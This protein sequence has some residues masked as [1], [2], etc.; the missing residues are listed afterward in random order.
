MIISK[1]SHLN[2]L[3]KEKPLLPLIEEIC[4]V[5]Q[6]LL[7]RKLEENMKWEKPP[8]DLLHWIRVLNL[9]DDIFEKQIAHY[10]LALPHPKLAE[11]APDDA[12]LLVACLRFSAMLLDHCTNR[13]IYASADR[14]FHL[15]NAYTIDVKLAALEV[16]YFLGERYFQLSRAKRFA[17][18][19][20]VRTRLVEFATCFPPP[21]PASFIQKR[22]ASQAITASA[23]GT[24]PPS[25][26]ASLLSSN[27]APAPTSNNDHYSLVDTLD[28]KKKYPSKWKSLNF[29][30][31]SAD[32]DKKKN[33]KPTEGVATF[34]LSDEQVRKMSLEQMYDKACES[35]PKE[36]WSAFSLAAL[37]AKAFNTKL[38][39]SMKLRSK[40]LRLKCVAVSCVVFNC[41]SDFTSFNL[42]EVEPYTFGALVA[43]ISPEH[44]PLI[45][46]DIF[47]WALKTLEC[48]SIK[49]AWGSELVRHLGGNVSHGLLYQLLRY[50]NKKI[51]NEDDDCF[52]KG[53]LVFFTMLGNLVDSKSLSP[54][55]AS[56]GLLTDL[57]QF[58]NVRTKFRWTCS[59][60][61]NN[62]AIFL[63]A[64]P[65][66]ITEF[67]ND[68]GFALLVD[69]INYE[70]GF[71]LE[72]PEFGGGTPKDNNTYYSITLRQVN[73]IRNLLKLV[74]HLIQSDAGDRLRNLF[75]SSILISFNKIISNPTV[76]GPFVVAATL[77]AV[78]HII[79]NEPTAYSILKE[80][81]VIDT[82]V[83]NYKSLFLPS[84]ELIL[85][86]LEILGAI[87]LNKDGL[88]TVSRAFCLDIF[89]NSF[90]N[91]SI[92]KE[93]LRTEMNTSIGCS[94]DE[95]ARHYPSLRPYII[96][97]VCRL[98]EGFADFVEPKLEPIRFYTSE[99]YGSFYNSPTDEVISQEVG[100]SEIES[101]E[102]SEGS[103]L[104]D[105]FEG[106]FCGLL[107]DSGQWGKDI[108][109]K[110]PSFGLQRL[111]VMLNTPSDYTDS[112]T[113][114]NICA[115]LK[116]VTDEDHSSGLSCLI[117]DIRKYLKEPRIQ[118]FIK[119]TG[120]ESYFYG[121]SENPQEATEVLK[122]LNRLSTCLY[123]LTET[124]LNPNQMVN[125]VFD[126]F[127]VQFGVS[128]SL[129][130]DLLKLMQRSIIEELTFRT[131]LPPAVMDQTSPV[132]ESGVAALPLQI[133]AKQ[134]SKEAAHESHTS[135]KYKNTLQMRFLA[136]RF[137]HHVALIFSCI[138][139]SC[140]HR[141]QDYFTESWREWAVQLTE[142]M[143][144]S[145]YEL[146]ASRTMF[147]SNL[148]PGYELVALNIILSILLS[149]DR[150]KDVISTSLLL[151]FY[152]T[153]E[154][155]ADVVNATID[156]FNDI[157][158]LPEEVLADVTK[159]KFIE[160]SSA[161]IK[162]NFLTRALLLLSQVV[163]PAYVVRLP[164]SSLFYN[165]EYCPS[166]SAVTDGILSQGSL[167]CVRLIDSLVG[168][169]SK[170][171]LSDDFSAFANLPAETVDLIFIIVR[172]VWSLEPTNDYYPLDAT[173][174]TPARGEAD[175][176]QKHLKIDVYAADNILRI[177]KSI[178]HIPTVQGEYT[179]T[180]QGDVND[181]DWTRYK[182]ILEKTDYG[183]RFNYDC[184]KTEAGTEVDRMRRVIGDTLFT[185]T[186]FKIAAFTTKPID[187]LIFLSKFD[188]EKF[189]NSLLHRIVDLSREKSKAN[190]FQLSNLVHLFY[191]FVCREPFLVR[192]KLHEVRKAAFDQFLEFFLSEME[193]YPELGDSEYFHAGLLCIEPVFSQTPPTMLSDVDPYLPDM[194]GIISFKGRCSKAVLAL[195]PKDNMEAAIELCRFAYLLAKE[196]EFKQDVIQSTLLHSIINKMGTYVS[197]D[198]RDQLKGLQDSLILLVRTCFENK[199]FLQTI[200]SSEITRLYEKQQS[201]RRDLRRL[202]DE[203]RFLVARDA[204][205]YIETA[206]KLL[207]LENFDGK[208]QSGD[209]VFLLKNE[210]HSN[211]EDTNNEDTQMDVDGN[212]ELKSTG[213]VHLL[214]SQMM[215][216]SKQ[217][218]TSSPVSPEEEQKSDD[219]MSKKKLTFEI[220]MQN[221]NFGYLCFL[222]QTLTEL[223]GS[224]KNAKLEFIT[225]SKKGVYDAKHKPRSTS[226]NFFIH[227]LLLNHLLASLSGP[228]HQ[229]REAVSSLAKVSLLALVSTT[230]LENDAESQ[231][232]ME[233]PDMA[234][235][236]KFTV[237]V[238]SKTLKDV[239]PGSL[240][241]SETYSKIYEVFDLCACLLSSK[242]RELCYPLLNKNATKADQ[243]YI[244]A[245][246]LDSQLPNQI[247]SVIA[248]L[249]LNFPNITKVTKVG[250]KPLSSLA[251]I[252]QSHA[253][254]FESN[255]QGEKDEEDIEDIEDKD[256]TPDL[257]RNSTLGMY[258]VDRESEEDSFDDEGEPLDAIMSGSDVSGDETEDSND[259][260]SES[261]DD[262]MMEEDLEGALEEGLVEGRYEGYDSQDSENDIEIIDELEIHS[263]SG[264]DDE[265]T[266][267]DGFYG[268]SDHYD[269]GGEADED[270]EE[271][272][273][274]LD[275]D[276]DE[277]DEED[278]EDIDDV[279]VLDDW[280]MAFG[281]EAATPSFREH[282]STLRPDYEWPSEE[283]I[284]GATE[285]ESNFESE[286]DEED[287]E[288][289]TS[290]RTREFVTSFVDALRP[291]GQQNFSSFFNGLIHR[292]SQPDRGL[293]RGSI[294]IGDPRPY[295]DFFSHNGT[296][297]EIIVDD[298]RNN[299]LKKSLDYM[300]IRS[301]TERWREA[302]A[303]HFRLFEARL[304]ECARSSIVENIKEASYEIFKKKEE[305]KE[306]LRKQKEEK[307]AK[308]KE[309]QRKKRE[310]E[311]RQREAEEAGQP[312]TDREPVLLWIGDREVDISG[313][314]IDPGFFEALP[315]DMREEVFTQHVRERRA[316]ASNTAG[317]V[318]EIDPDFLSALPEQIRDDILQQESLARRYS[319]DGFRYF[320]DNEEGED[321]L[322]DESE[323]DDGNDLHATSSQGEQNEARERKPT[324][325]KKRTYL[326]TP[327]LDRS[328][329]AS[330]V[331]L[332]FVPRPINQRENIYL[333]LLHICDNKHTRVDV[334]G[335]LIAILF[336]G[337]VSQKALERSFGLISAK[338]HSVKVGQTDFSKSFPLGATPV[339]IGYQMIEAV[340]YLVEKNPALRLFLLTEH[341]NP[342]LSTRQ[343]KNRLKDPATCEE[344]YPI[345][346]LLKLL[347]NP[348]LTEEHFFTELLASVLHFGTRPL[349]LLRE[350]KSSV[351]L[352]FSTSFIPDRNLRLIIR[353]LAS[354]ECT[355]STFRRALSAMQHLSLLKNAQS[356][357]SDELSGKSKL[358]GTHI[359]R[360][361]K[362]LTA[363]IVDDPQTDIH[364][365]KYVS[366]FTAPSS[367]QSKLLRVL[368]ALDYMYETN[369][370]QKTEN[371]ESGNEKS[372]IDQLTVLYNHLQLGLLWDALSDCL[373]VLEESSTLSTI[374]TALLPLIEALMV[375]CKHSKVKEIQ[376]KDVM[377][378]EAKKIDFTKEP[379]ESLFFSF[380][381]EHKKI[382]NQMVRSNPN[383]M[384]GPF[385]MLVRNPRVLEFDNKK[386]YFD[387][388][389]HEDPENSHK[390]AVSIRRD[391]VFL[392][393]YRAL[394]FKSLEEF[395]KARLEIAFKGEAGIDAGGVT[396]EWYQVL[397]RQMFNPDYALF[398]AVASDETTFHPNRTSYINP[399]HLSFFK[400]I[401]RVIGKAIYDGSFLDCHFSR[402][403]YKAILNR[404]VSL[405]DMENLDLE[406]FK[407]LMWMLEND[408]TDIITEDFSVETDD[409]GEHKVIDLVENGRNIPVTEENKQEYVRLVV[410]YRLQTSVKE[411]MS[412]F[413]TGF[414]EII[415]QD[416][417]AIFDEQE[418][419]LLISGLPDIDVQD[420]KN[421]TV[422]NNY[423]PSSEQIQWF[424]RAVK[425]FD[426]EERAKLLQFATGTSKVPLNGFKELRG[427]NG[428][429][430]F[431][432]HRD[433]GSAD[434]LPSSHTCFNQID[435]PA[436]ESYETLRG[437]LLLAITEGH[438]GF[439]LA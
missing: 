380:T 92:A 6:A 134:P 376:A 413:I 204:N 374:A 20:E 118:G 48:L 233:D 314:D 221:S 377:K 370:N 106:F 289:F 90:R 372:G 120:P 420:W 179:P 325:A 286:N 143:A 276:S 327:L 147:D 226:L 259:S 319:N 216:V 13:N 128:E 275:E 373:R 135:A 80:A 272:D 305:E 32:A 432:I 112:S 424:W 81:N 244:G 270:P 385:S 324:A 346:L 34:H 96:D 419:E 44:F 47:Y 73:F 352:L 328:G 183:T 177:A 261:E 358:L 339:S 316:N 206:S 409:Y 418:L 188:D 306:E 283:D 353:I 109:E 312:A 140:I 410:E 74:S 230:V 42:F 88:L 408:I 260:D 257:F 294:H 203:T 25:T 318:R 45:S 431:S 132:I 375:I 371:V 200:F 211:V 349:I 378:Y 12:H 56:G 330:L 368:T 334:L 75:D 57:M 296:P 28:H 422:Y 300:V 78:S 162:V 67:A 197:T 400:F 430:K 434:R 402:A 427:A 93:L 332:L 355:N 124:Y 142:R 280:L 335:M 323:A 202:V 394:F 84:G 246:F 123:V 9:F 315:E 218:W 210:G 133:Y 379:I 182:Q 238:I 415:P 40:L 360:D 174:M 299:T 326:A 105:N 69:T 29:Q 49:R 350:K 287:N 265:G 98:N 254:F 331:R 269:E 303:F 311:S 125:D 412:N 342:Y 22:A 307:A 308:R 184:V 429:C 117:I 282:H 3:E 41:T 401:G 309:E 159:L 267:S 107:Q 228:E 293:L 343:P 187:H 391:Q 100:Q 250:L 4:G 11:I 91:L 115:I 18:P 240:E 138:S 176:L 141:R 425:S 310:E 158:E 186:M 439:G 255:T 237:S 222:L 116:Y 114:S 277:E 266:G 390:L 89:F 247:T 384:S 248:N 359:I 264:S 113:I 295:D 340:F 207:R 399:E 317:E 258:D 5:E 8:G 21:I 438:E 274:D 178:K 361:L 1:R 52:E 239:L 381:D 235:V 37:N 241:L 225:F 298:K 165:K 139:R 53:Y 199:Q 313:T 279:E 161:S 79:H 119:H 59:A 77:D 249:D 437:S 66:L 171:I 62:I 30:Y 76:F 304:I 68:N 136:Y 251:K 50:I 153:T 219:H 242:F 95:L 85:S 351:P 99:Q 363:S 227:Q 152:H 64:S 16:A 271:M 421:H 83:E 366:S 150:G 426:N 423:S 395:K 398:T 192:S 196:D 214:L 341:E 433:Y 17:A 229:R 144:R 38:Y 10:D 356:V 43:L 33:K 428:G 126:S 364:N 58:L 336:D 411:Q 190:L 145:L 386:N 148:R 320:D 224:Y 367:E 284:H 396:R 292:T 215:I 297:F 329:V 333:T 369:Q 232:K 94:V 383:L 149:K 127:M 436:Y 382:L 417:V 2:K 35:L 82:I 291:L 387:R 155:V 223:L 243:Y 193:N 54:R 288:D 263:T 36:T 392:D 173:R 163:S 397:S 234:I 111:I 404:P 338:A 87:S 285:D 281:E 181:Q 169:H 129:I 86:L 7:A 23:S 51:R 27:P 185:S 301:T 389:L 122:E 231:P 256:E 208:V 137:Q 71:A 157:V 26:S 65:E 166:D 191:K 102:G 209:K 146:F 72:Y 14:V 101:W 175:F 220:L 337:L 435:L 60:A 344:K 104:V 154:L 121:F 273:E 393:S 198:K 245:A 15:I 406:Y 172:S 151:F 348:L 201:T 403:V 268:F 156:T 46:N 217:D 405:K 213:L 362:C 160:N 388:Q 414:H 236:R 164:F 24:P 212:H 302:F 31:F 290:R 170:M 278:E 63:N 321:G 55:L 407:S 354:N 180:L 103:Y 262:D 205:L 19:K 131:K 416:L 347:E 168:G 108:S 357:F 365:N 97:N 189:V 39:D 61:V 195:Q 130:E 253:E 194:S 110:V 345:N 252:R 70:V 322:D 167:Q